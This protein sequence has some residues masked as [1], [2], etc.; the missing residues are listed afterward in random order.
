MSSW[1]TTIR[2]FIP[3]GGAAA[4]RA[5]QPAQVYGTAPA[6]TTG[7]FF[8]TDVLPFDPSAGRGRW[9][10]A[11]NAHSDAYTTF[12]GGDVLVSLGWYLMN[13]QLTLSRF[14]LV[15]LRLGQIWR[16]AYVLRTT[17]RLAQTLLITLMKGSGMKARTWKWIVG[18][19]APQSLNHCGLC[20]DIVARP[21]DLLGARSV[22][23][24]LQFGLRGHEATL[25]RCVLLRSVVGLFFSTAAA[26]Q[27][28]A[29]AR[30]L[31]LPFLEHRLRFI[32]DGFLF[33]QD[34]G[35]CAMFQFVE[36]GLLLQIGDAAQMVDDDSAL[37]PAFIFRL[38]LDPLRNIL[39]QYHLELAP[40][41]ERRGGR[42]LLF[43]SGCHRL[44][45]F[46]RGQPSGMKRDGD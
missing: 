36:L 17:I 7:T 30:V 16:P 14:F 9:V 4:N 27:E 43:S 26:G 35:A 34:F 44:K 40:T 45:L 12:E 46:L 25:R 29:H 19:V 28:V 3:P 10:V 33:P 22:L 18:Y 23:P 32:D 6:G 2:T 37:R 41:F 42:C 8:V 21:G 1:S 38:L 5:I 24:Q 13:V 31:E 20:G 11:L 39:R 15:R